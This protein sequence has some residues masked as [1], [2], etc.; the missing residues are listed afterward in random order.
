MH[1]SD[2]DLALPGKNDPGS[3]D[4]GSEDQAWTPHG[5]RAWPL[6]PSTFTVFPGNSPCPLPLPSPPVSERFLDCSDPPCPLFLSM[7]VI[8]ETMFLFSKPFQ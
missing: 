4:P 3:E 6:Q 7:A 1:L 2:T 8:G 5:W